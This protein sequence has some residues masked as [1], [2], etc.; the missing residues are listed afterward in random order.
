MRQIAHR[1]L[2]LAQM[3]FY[4]LALLQALSCLLF[5]PLLTAGETS[6]PTVR[7]AQSGITSSSWPLR[8]AQGRF[9]SCHLSRP[10]VQSARAP[11]G[12]YKLGTVHEYLGPV[13]FAAE[14]A[15][16]DYIRSNRPQIVSFLK[17]MIEGQRFL[18]DPRNKEDAIAIH[19]KLL[20]SSRDV[21]EGDYRFLVEEFK[22]FPTDGSVNKQAMEKTMELRARAGRYEE[23]KV[24][25]YAQYVD[26]S[27]VEEAQR[28]LGLK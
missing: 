26:G 7:F 5:S 15:H 8:G 28:Q 22:P 23:K 11:G 12:I 10:A 1:I 18:Y 21:A 27:L 20:K 16:E 3:P 6:L 24:P 13:Q 9:Y 2:R 14:F 17:A 19:M 25:S 4:A